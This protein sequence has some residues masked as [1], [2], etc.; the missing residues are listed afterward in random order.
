ML[1]KCY[2][3]AKYYKESYSTVR[4]VYKMIRE[5]RDE[6]SLVFIVEAATLIKQLLEI[7]Q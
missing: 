7:N 1:A 6:R 4:E 5:N 3:S 2:F